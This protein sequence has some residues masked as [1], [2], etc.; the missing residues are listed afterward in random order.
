MAAIYSAS[1]PL[2]GGISSVRYVNAMLVLGC[3]IYQLIHS[4]SRAK[5][6][7]VGVLNDRLD[8]FSSCVAVTSMIGLAAL[9][10]MGIIVM[11]R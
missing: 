4:Y 1:F 11:V 9:S 10:T 7:V 5:Q 6:I 3:T 8:R 2:A